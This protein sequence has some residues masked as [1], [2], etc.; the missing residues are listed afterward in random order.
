[1]KTCIL[2]LVS[3]T[4]IAT[5]IA[6]SGPKPYDHGTC[7]VVKASLRNSIGTIIR[8]EMANFNLKEDDAYRKNYGS[9]F[10]E[11]LSHYDT[12]T[13]LKAIEAVSYACPFWISS[14]SNALKP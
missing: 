9:Y 7:S 10:D 5:S 1:M 3:S 13:L 4:L 6:I 11:A 2:L 14:G 12:K 8:V